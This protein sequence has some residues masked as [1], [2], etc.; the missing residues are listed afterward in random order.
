MVANL[1]HKRRAK[2]R[3]NILFWHAKLDQIRRNIM[4]RRVVKNPNFIIA[5]IWMDDTMMNPA[6]IL[7]NLKP[8]IAL[9]LTDFEMFPGWPKHPLTR[10]RFP[11]QSQER[12]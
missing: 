10:K 6:P 1:P 11:F 8:A 5:N 4:L 2:T 3:N 12:T 9:T 7:P